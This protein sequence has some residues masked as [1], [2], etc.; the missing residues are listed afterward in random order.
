[1]WIVSIEASDELLIGTPLSVAKARTLIVPPDGQNIEAKA[2]D[3]MQGTP[4]Q[5]STQH[6]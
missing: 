5:P 2:I 3:D 4:W 1:M 6:R